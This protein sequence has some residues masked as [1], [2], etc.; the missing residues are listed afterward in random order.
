MG[1]AKLNIWISGM[2]DP[3]GI[4]SG[5]WWVNIY[6]CDG[7]VL[8]WCR[9]RY[10]GL[11]ANC[12]HLEVEVP[13]GC[14]YVKAFYK[15]FTD[16]A[17]V[18]AR[19][20]ETTCVKLFNPGLYVSGPTFT[21]VLRELARQKIIKPEV[22]RRLEKAIKPVLQ[23]IPRPKR[24]FELAHLEGVERLLRKRKPRRRK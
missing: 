2:N 6:T 15:Y 9:S 22:A 13:P 23:Q 19:C 21:N 11:E 20:E 1:M 5:R 12:G 3:C 7:E 24:E 8:E 10:E 4:D 16:A 17:I 18:Q 14:Y